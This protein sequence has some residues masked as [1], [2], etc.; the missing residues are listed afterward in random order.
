[1]RHVTSLTP[2]AY[3]TEPA[4][5]TSKAQ[6][7]DMPPPSPPHWTTWEFY[8]YYVAAALVIPYM[9]YV[10]MYLSSPSRP[11]YAKYYYYLVDGWMGGRMRDN[12][13]HQYRLLRDHGLLLLVLML[14]YAALS[15]LVRWIASRSGPHA[16]HVRMAFLGVTG[17]VFVT[18]LHGINAVKLFVFSVFNYVLASSAAWLPPHIVQAMIWAYNGGMLFLVFYTCLLYTSPSPRDLSTS[19]M[20]SSA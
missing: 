5:D 18:A 7:S 9:I 12:S 6:A 14:S 3:A 8:L 11:E 16:Q 19:R 15:R 4:Q 1:M 20:P 10:P 13:D 17:A 2:N